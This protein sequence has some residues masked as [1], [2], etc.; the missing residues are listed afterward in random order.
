MREKYDNV[1]IQN[2]KVIQFDELTDIEGKADN[3]EEN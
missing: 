2:P 1:T 3:K